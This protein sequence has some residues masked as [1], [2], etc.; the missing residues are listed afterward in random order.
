MRFNCRHVLNR[1]RLSQLQGCDCVSL[2]AAT[3]LGLPKELEAVASGCI[4]SSLHALQM[5]VRHAALPSQVSIRGRPIFLQADTSWDA[6][7][8]VSTRRADTGSDCTSPA[9]TM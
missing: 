7:S 2:R 3:E 6:P 8:G 5:H 9:A 4:T 1:M